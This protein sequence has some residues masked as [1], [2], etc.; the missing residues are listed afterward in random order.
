MSLMLNKSL[1]IKQ[2]FSFQNFSKIQD[3][4]KHFKFQ[5]KFILILFLTKRDLLFQKIEIK[6]K[7]LFLEI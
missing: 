2:I 5:K 1:K 4:R 6:S 7:K 3:F